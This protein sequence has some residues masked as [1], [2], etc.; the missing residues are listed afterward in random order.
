MHAAPPVRMV[1][2]PEPAWAAFGAAC[3]A[4]AAANLAGWMA[5]MLDSSV[6]VAAAWAVLAAGLATY[7][8]WRVVPMRGSLAW[9]GAVWH[10]APQESAASPGDLQVMI[11]LGPWMLLRFAPHAQPRRAAWLA[12]SSRQGGAQWPSWRSA[13][14]SR[15]PELAGLDSPGGASRS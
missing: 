11:D 1:L 4:C 7:R 12:V 15:R 14:F 8:A 2:G 9:D 3:V 13:F 5:L 10:W 6:A